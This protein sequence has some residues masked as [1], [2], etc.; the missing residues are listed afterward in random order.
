MPSEIPESSSELRKWILHAR[1][2][3]R[4]ITRGLKG[5][6]KSLSKIEQ[7]TAK[8]PRSAEMKDAPARG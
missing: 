7:I 2:S 1:E 5:L 8:A 3:S 6:D 4:T